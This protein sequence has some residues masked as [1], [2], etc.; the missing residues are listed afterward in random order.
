MGVSPLQQQGQAV[1]SYVAC[2]SARGRLAGP[3]CIKK[4]GSGKRN[5][6]AI[7]GLDNPKVEQMKF[8][9]EEPLGMKTAHPRSH[10]LKNPSEAYWEQ[11]KIRKRDEHFNTAA[12]I[13]GAM[14]VSGLFGHAYLS[15]W[16]VAWCKTGNDDECNLFYPPAHGEVTDFHVGNINP[17]ASERVS[18]ADGMRLLANV[19][20]NF[21]HV[22]DIPTQA[23]VKA[24]SRTT[25]DTPCNVQGAM[26]CQHPVSP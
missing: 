22:G 13:A 12:R 18:R 5:G 9:H 7:V 3:S 11:K 26:L 1:S 14:S 10:W 4:E 17:V 16:P 25:T 15:G 8:V 23:E 24:A 20:G 6:N 21:H 2:Y 19:W